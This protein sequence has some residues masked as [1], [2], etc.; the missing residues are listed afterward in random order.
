M[1]IIFF[2]G[3]EVTVGSALPECDTQIVTVSAIASGRSSA[4]VIELK[5]TGT[6]GA[7][8]VNFQYFC[9]ADFESEANEGIAIL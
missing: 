9:E 4:Q 2:I 8:G 6:S 5:S 3:N 1:D 7:S